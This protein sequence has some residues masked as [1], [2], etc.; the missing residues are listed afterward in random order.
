MLSINLHITK[1]KPKST[2]SSFTNCFAVLLNA[3]WILFYEEECKHLPKNAKAN[4]AIAVEVG[5]ETH[6][7]VSSGDKFDTWGVDGVVRWATK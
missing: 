2:K 3:T 5:V 1:I 7:V 6:R 4:F